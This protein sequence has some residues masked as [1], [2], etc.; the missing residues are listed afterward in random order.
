MVSLVKERQPEK[1]D[2]DASLAVGC[3]QPQQSR[4]HVEAVPSSEHSTAT[5]LLPLETM[6]C[7][8]GTSANN[9]NTDFRSS[10]DP[11]VPTRLRVRKVLN[12]NIISPINS[13]Q[14]DFDDSDEDPNFENVPN[15]ANESSESE[16]EDLG[17]QEELETQAA[18][19]DSD[20]E[21]VKKKGKKRIAHPEEWRINKSQLQRNSGQSY[22]SASKSRRVYKERQLRASCG[23]KCRLECS[24]KI[25]ETRR[26]EIFS[27]YWALGDLSK[28]RNCIAANTQSIKPKYRYSSTENHR[29]LNSAFYFEV[30]GERIRVCKT[31]FKA[32]LDI[33]DRPIRTVLAKKDATGFV[34]TDLR[35]KH[36]KHPT[37]G[38]EVKN[39]V[40]NHID[41]IPRIESHYLR[42]QTERSYI[43]G[44]KSLSDLYRDYRQERIES[45][46]PYAN[47]LMY[48]R[49]FN[50]E[51]NIGFF[52]PKKD[53]CELCVAFQN[54]EGEEKEAL[55]MR[56]EQHQKEKQLSRQ[57]KEADKVRANKR[58]IVAV[59]DLQAVL[60]TPRGDVS[61]FYY[62]S[63]LNNYNFTISELK[64]GATECYLWH[65]GE[66]NRGAEEIATCVL[67][68][69]EKKVM[70]AANTQEGP[71]DIVFYSDNCCGQQKNKYLVAMYI[72]VLKKFTTVNSITHK[73][74][75]TGHTQNEGDSVHSTIEK[76]I[77]KA[78]KSGPIYVPSQYAQIIRTAKKRGKPYNVNEM[79]HSD[80]FKIK[81]LVDQLGLNFNAVKISEIKIFTI[82][83]ESPTKLYCKTSYS[84]FDFQEI[85]L[86]KTTRRNSATIANTVPALKQ[87]YSSALKIK[88]NKKKDLLSLLKNNH[89]KKYYADFYNN[90]M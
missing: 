48:S 2:E 5:I 16:I 25:D 85:D 13:D 17:R 22:V 36:D 21:P 89:I 60:P 40:R 52:S 42:A 68:F 41:S 44:G 53:Q 64:T 77:K 54:A 75:I 61:V 51:Y 87:A 69:I 59:Y 49:I 62:K 66:G 29:N 23:E 63:K 27:S 3:L 82:N 74:L 28:Q 70:D 20:E 86:S 1:T 57:E 33:N 58:V 31:F 9:I 35:G 14:E 71:L 46:L 65:E 45:N 80:F 12:F 47:L 4:I 6:E 50:E 84:D 88:E 37:V 26:Q 73:Y 39:S 78:L 11:L 72:Y 34:A 90:L 10:Y 7:E 81:D 56:Y 55:R 19:T 30:N 24:K 43:E 38:A 8:A 83:K 67:K 79:S 32:T 76:E 18:G 15:I